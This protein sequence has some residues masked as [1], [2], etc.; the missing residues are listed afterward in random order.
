MENTLSQ[1]IEYIQE[2]LLE[3]DDSV[4]PDSP[5]FSSG[6]LDSF[7][8]LELLVFLEET[9]AVKIQPQDI[10]PANIDTP[11]SIARMVGEN[12]SN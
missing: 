10:N 7:H 6:L 2:D 3:T 5:L 11:S 12:N 8:L 1:I 9:F 4:T